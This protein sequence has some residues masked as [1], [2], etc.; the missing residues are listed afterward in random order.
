MKSY[1]YLPLFSFLLAGMT[2]NASGTVAPEANK[3]IDL[4]QTK[5][6][7]TISGKVTDTSGQPVV[8]ATI[9]IKSSNKGCITDV[10]G[11]F[12]LKAQEGDI[13][14]VSYMGAQAK[15]IHVTPASHYAVTLQEDS[16][17][18]DEVVVTALGIKK[19]KKALGYSVSDLNAGEL[20]KNKQVN[21]INSLEGKIPGL[22]ITQSGGAAGAGANIVIRGGNS[23]SESRDN[24]P[25]F[26]VD[27]IIYDNS[28]VNAGNDLTNGVSKTA[29]TFSNRVMD[30]NP[31]DIEN[32]SV[33]KGAAAAALYGSKAANGAIIIT[34][35]K[36]ESGAIRVNVDSKYT[37]SWA[38]RLPKLQNKYGRGYYNQAGTFDDYT[39]DSWG[40]EIEG[41]SY[42]NIGD[43][44]Q[45]GSTFDNSVSV[46]GGGKNNSFY[47][48]GSNFS[49]TGIIPTTN[50]HKTTFRFNGEQ[51][52]GD[53]LTI[54]AGVAYTQANTRK[55]LTAGGLYGQGGNGAMTAVYG[56]SRSD[57]MKHYLNDDGTKYRMFEGRQ[58]LQ[59]DIENPYWILNRNK[60]TDET[61]RFTGSIHADLKILPWWHV[62][63]RV[64]LDKYSTDSYTY[65]A[66][67][68]AVL[69]KYQNGF[70]STARVDYQYLS[71]NVMSNMNKTFGD[72]DFSL[73]LGTTSED[74]KVTNNTEWG[75]D[76]VTP[77][78]ISFNNIAVDNQFFKRRTTR[79]RL[80][81]GY[82]EFRA[83]YK[84]MVYLNFSG[85]ND[86]SSTLPKQ[87][88]SYFYPSV[89]GSFV[90]TEL[91]PKNNVLSFGKLR[92][93]WAQVGKDADPYSTNFYL[94]PVATVNNGHLAIGNSWTGGS[95]NLKPE[96]QTS[97]EFGA[98]LRFF[99]GRLG[100][101]YTY[102]YSKTKD[103]LCAPRLTQ[104]T[105]YIFL[106]LNGGSVI[107]KGMELSI[108][109]K[110][111][112]TKDF[113][114][115]TTLNLSG[116]RGRLGQFIEGVDIFYLTDAQIG[117]AKAGS[118]PNGY[119]QGLTGDKFETAVGSDGKEQYVVDETTGLYKNTKVQTNIV[120][121]REPNL[122]G[123]FNNSLTYK[124]FNLSF[125][126]DM[127]FGGAIYNGTEYYLASKGLSEKTL[128][129]QSVTVSG[130]SSATGNP[131]SYTYEA[132]KTYNVNGAEKSGR[133][134]IQQYWNNYSKN[135][136]N[137]I[138]KTNW[139][140]LRSVSLSY[141][142]RD[143]LKGQHVIK[144]LV[145]TVTGTNLLLLTNYK[146]MDPEVSVA[147]SGT[148]GSGASGMDYCGVPATAG[149]SFGVNVTF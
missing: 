95:Y 133:Y 19:D 144:G 120:G 135:A 148:G 21:V 8:G 88:R 3:V 52:Y 9:R 111:I 5:S 80:I 123:G 42:D 51:K 64:G 78:V 28:T 50:Y 87:N 119:F 94:W 48:S 90:F 34:T 92:A 105:G 73:L 67:G 125:L 122:I 84:N 56:W 112:V 7:K 108:T 85:R 77:G 66:P 29:T 49:Q 38:N 75:Y 146:G 99:N 40:K 130:I 74:T 45:G 104:S 110:P 57:D 89:S 60:M 86:W 102:Y 69:E 129:R 114:W 131:V 46:S 118:I 58:D 10:D 136:Y 97:Y 116:N 37:Y 54:G 63:A 16:R 47:L 17:S 33:L 13:L 128:D 101:D 117:G 41:G 145:A 142:F 137:F 12:S 115:E 24:Q 30:I 65:R 81:G 23:A 124:N 15:E 53:I 83:S 103:Q 44:F 59:D 132:D 76:F 82:G 1:Y 36:G 20:M 6:E 14:T 100:L 70:L 31:E 62:S 141:D 72:F 32:I 149:F 91:L 11:K 109:A 71:T 27:G 26:V 139:L 107:N 4:L 25:L 35:K 113:Q 98:E 127:R 79:H 121:N 96:I 55:T 106:T 134:M 140:R 147:G 22:N 2:A 39:T 18:L 143:L 138:T 61:S 93:S 68:G 43:F 126:F